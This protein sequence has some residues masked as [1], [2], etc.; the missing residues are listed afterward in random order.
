MLLHLASAIHKHRVNVI[1]LCG[2]VLTGTALLGF[3]IYLVPYIE[4][5]FHYAQYSAT[6]VPSLLPRTSSV[7]A[8]SVAPAPA[9]SG[10]STHAVS[11]PTLN[12]PKL[13]ISVPVVP[14]VD[15]TRQKTYN[16][17]LK[18]GVAHIQGTAELTSYAGNTVI[19]GHSSRFAPSGTPYDAIFATLPH[20]LVGDDIE[21][22]TPNS[23][24]QLFRVTASKVIS[25][26]DT[27]ALDSND[28]RVITLLTCWPLGTPLKR[29]E[30]QATAVL[31]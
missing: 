13:G 26:D 7:K 9:S 17:A 2:G 28:Q 1:A 27:T 3:I 31:P 12:I 4:A 11:Q 6:Y 5:Q 29:W 30:V 15:T 8:R 22:L 21:L 10:Q 19:I 16:L 24:P 23:D 25:P 14:D 20:L 18:K